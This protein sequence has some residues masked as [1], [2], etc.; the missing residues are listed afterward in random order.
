M[1]QCILI[2]RLGLYN[3]N[4]VIVPRN[5]CLLTE[6]LAS[7]KCSNASIPRPRCDQPAQLLAQSIEARIESGIS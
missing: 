5:H 3:Q 2:L 4:A 6:T 7:R 1:L